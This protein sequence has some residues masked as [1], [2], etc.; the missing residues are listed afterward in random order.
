MT[1]TSL[2]EKLSYIAYIHCQFPRLFW[3]YYEVGTQLDN[4]YIFLLEISTWLG[5]L[6]FILVPV[7]RSPSLGD[8]YCSMYVSLVWVRNIDICPPRCPAAGRH[9]S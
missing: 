8:C 3:Y 1:S 6:P 4:Y 5:T 2:G 9:Q 7:T